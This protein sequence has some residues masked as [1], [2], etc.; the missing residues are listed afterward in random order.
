MGYS[1][2]LGI[3]AISLL[4]LALT[5][6]FPVVKNGDDKLKRLHGVELSLALRAEFVGGLGRSPL[7]I[8]EHEPTPSDPVSIAMNSYELLRLGYVVF[9]DDLFLY[10]DDW[11]V[12]TML[13]PLQRVHYLWNYWVLVFD[14]ISKEEDRRTRSRSGQPRLL[15]LDDPRLT[16]PPFWQTSACA[17]EYGS[18]QPTGYN[19]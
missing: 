11:D 17:I 6:S 3:L 19:K 4:P 1:N 16:R 2:K 12:L 5:R 9:N 15:Q 18:S 7:Y 13:V 8:L 10:F 14:L